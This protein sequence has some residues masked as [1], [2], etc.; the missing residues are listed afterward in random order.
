[1]PSSF[2]F[3]NL[4]P[5]LSPQ[6]TKSVF[7]VTELPAVAPRLIIL[8]LIPSGFDNGYQFGKTAEALFDNGV[9]E[10]GKVEPSVREHS[11]KYGRKYY[12]VGEGSAETYNPAVDSV[13]GKV[14]QFPCRYNR[15]SGKRIAACA[16][17]VIGRE[18][19]GSVKQRAVY[20][21]V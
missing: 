3:V 15:T 12:K 19:H 9:L 18:G 20:Y 14:L 6:I 4:L 17:P 5:G 1:M 2:A 21:R 13:T 16:V 10:M 7:L 11:L 8:L